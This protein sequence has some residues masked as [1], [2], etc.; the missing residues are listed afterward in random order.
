MQADPK[1]AAKC[2]HAAL[3][4]EIKALLPNE[5]GGYLGFVAADGNG[6]GQLLQ[7][8]NDAG[9]YHSFTDELHRLTIDAI[10]AAMRSSG[11]LEAAIADNR[12]TVPL[13]PIVVAGDDMSFLVRKEHVVNFAAKLGE[14][15]AERSRPGFGRS[16]IPDV[17]EEFCRN[18]ANVAVARRH[19]PTRFRPTEV[20]G[21][22][23]S[24]SS[25][26]VEG[27]TLSMGV[28]IARRNFPIS[29]YQRLAASLRDSAKKMLRD[30]AN[31]A[32]EEGAIDFAVITSASAQSL[33]ELRA[34]YLREGNLCL[35]SRPYTLR[36][37]RHLQNLAT[38]LTSVPRSKRKYLYQELFAGEARGEDAFRFAQRGLNRKRLEDALRELS[39]DN[40]SIFRIDPR[41]RLRVTPLVDALELAELLEGEEEL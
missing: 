32:E 25:A 27:L 12:Q 11:M 33:E 6:I 3:P 19:F 17:I 30:R 36:E 21:E 1:F 34:R 5:E 14:T 18:P 4:V 28:A 13:V 8:I 35:T 2:P 9:L 38:T 16:T 40:G 29:A 23:S 10:T 31:P 7:A 37:F 20:G 24:S 41:T 15:F 22:M 26:R 39:Y